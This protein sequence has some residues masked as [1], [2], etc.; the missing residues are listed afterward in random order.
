MKGEVFG[1][2]PGKGGKVRCNDV[3]AREL[4]TV[5]L[6]LQFS[7]DEVITQLLLFNMFLQH[8]QVLHE[9]SGFQIPNHAYTKS[10][11]I[12]R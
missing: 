2:W 10:G 9:F 3:S 1:G 6:F 7:Q 12:R 5:F 8:V 11:G 4:C